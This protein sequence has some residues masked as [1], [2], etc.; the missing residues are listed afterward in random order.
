MVFVASVGRKDRLARPCP[1]P[2]QPPD[3]SCVTLFAIV[4]APGRVFER[5]LEKFYGGEPDPETL[6]R[7][8][9]QRDQAVVKGRIGLGG[10]AGQLI[11]SLRCPARRHGGC[12]PGSM[13]LPERRHDRAR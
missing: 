1:I 7:L 8:G 3:T 6:R 9:L 10:G 12:V 5:V 2:K 13:P 4:S 11:G